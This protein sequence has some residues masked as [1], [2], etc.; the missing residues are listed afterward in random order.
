MVLELDHQAAIL[1]DVDARA[2]EAFG[3]VVVRDAG[4]HPNDFRMLGENIVH[5]L[6]DAVAAPKDVDDVDIA[7]NVSDSPIDAAGRGLR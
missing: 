6:R 4:L 7:G 2:R 1:D 3:R 5:V